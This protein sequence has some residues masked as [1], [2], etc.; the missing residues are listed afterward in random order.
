MKQNVECIS[1]EI[2]WYEQGTNRLNTTI[3]LL[4]IR[5]LK[6]LLA[7]ATKLTTYTK[8]FTILI[9][10]YVLPAVCCYLNF[11]SECT[12]GVYSLS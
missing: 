9:T 5:M 8:V 12:R 1:S 10:T 3:C 2:F 7:E 6:T 11:S 4:N